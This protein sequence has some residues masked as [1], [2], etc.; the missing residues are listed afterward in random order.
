MFHQYLLSFTRSQ[1]R[2]SS[3]EKPR[4]LPNILQRETTPLPI[5]PKNYLPPN[6]NSEGPTNPDLTRRICVQVEI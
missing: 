3:P 5:I 1:L 2:A 6:L 4:M